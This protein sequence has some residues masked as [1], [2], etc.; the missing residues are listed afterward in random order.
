MKKVFFIR[1]CFCVFGTV[2]FPGH[3]GTSSGSSC[4]ESK[5]APYDVAKH[6]TNVNTMA[7]E[8]FEYLETRVERVAVVS[9]AGGDISDEE[10]RNPSGQEIHPCGA[11][12]EEFPRWKVAL[13]ARPQTSCAGSSSEIFVQSLGAVFQRRSPLLR[14][15]HRGSR[16]E[17]AAQDGPAI[18]EDEDASLKLHNPKYS[19]IAYP[20][21][22]KYQNSNGWVLSVMAAAESGLET[23]SEVMDYYRRMNFVPSQVEV[24]FFRQLGVGFVDNAHLDDHPES[25]GWFNFVSAE[26][27]Y[28]WLKI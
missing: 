22:L 5:Q 20:F 27:L 19:N 2:A 23:R 18:L 15:C 13:Q 10:F 25:G 6:Q 4:D 8:L 7:L 28:N 21:A 17:L 11:G 16:K 12:V 1:Y 26:S 9:R 24:G 14:F 3:T